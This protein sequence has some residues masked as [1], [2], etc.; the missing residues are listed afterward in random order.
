[1]DDTSVLRQLNN[2]GGKIEVSNQHPEELIKEAVA[3][4]QQADVVVM[5]LGESQGMTGE[6]AS[7]ADIRIPE[8]QRKLL[9]AVV[10]TGKP[11]VLVLSN[12]R[13][14]QL[15]WEDKHVSAIL[16]TWFLGTEAGHAIA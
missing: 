11:V 15:T 8:S 1:T 14:L 16:E 9:K 2:D 5:S 4:V 12:G 7:K 10:E 3:T 6:A 13:P